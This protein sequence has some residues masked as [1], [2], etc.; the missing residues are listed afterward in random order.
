MLRVVSHTNWGAD[1]KMLLRLHETLIL[2]KLD[3]GSQVYGSASPTYLK[4]L[5]PI[6]NTGLRLATG[7]FKSTPIESLYAESGFYSLEYRRTRLSLR[8]A[9]RINSKYSPYLFRNVY[10]T[11]SLPAFEAHP[12]YLKPFN[13]R[14]DALVTYF[15]V[16]SN[17]ISVHYPKVAPWKIENIDYCKE[18]ISV[19]KNSVTDIQFR[20]LFYEH[21]SEHNGSFPIF[22]D[23]SKTNEGVGYA[24]A[25]AN[26]SESR[27]IPTEASIYTAELLAVSLALKRVYQL[28]QKSFVIVSD[29]RSALMA[30]ES[31]NSPHP[32]VVEIQEWFYLITRQQKVVKFCWVPSHV[33]ITLNETAD[34]KAK[35]AIQERQ[36]TQRSLPFS[37]YYPV[38][39]K[40]IRN[41]W[42]NKWNNVAQTNKLRQVKD[43]VTKWPTS[44]SKNRRWEVVLSRLRLGHTRLT[45]GFLMENKPPLFVT[46]AMS[47]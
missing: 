14:L 36:V 11:V 39:D 12:R 41:D 3:Y 38:V 4:K 17:V 7:A 21:F 6:H 34:N 25:Y 2:S 29:S 8:Y 26:N 16:N 19:K 47:S 44:Y 1:R 24:I 37:D 10:N 46:A 18:L 43:T 45:H 9:L 20:N 31:Y 33:G 40:A 35:L 22:T 30:I 15:G 27:R 28:K 42:Q 23:G 5:D 32:I 13:I